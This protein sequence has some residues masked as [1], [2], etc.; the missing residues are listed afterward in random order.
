MSKGALRLGD[1]SLG[2][3]PE[4]CGHD[5]SCGTVTVNG[6]LSKGSQNV[7]INGKQAIRLGDPNTETDSCCGSSVGVVGSG[8]RT[9]LINGIPAGR[10]K[11]KL[12]QHAGSGNFISSSGNV[13]IGD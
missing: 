9:V 11:D 12:N 6:T 4:H 8:S 7:I 3:A 10:Q 2:S 13:F 1:K 5:P